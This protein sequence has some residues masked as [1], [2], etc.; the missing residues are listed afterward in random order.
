[1]L[2]HRDCSAHLGF[3]V[4]IEGL[5]DLDTFKEDIQKKNSK[6]V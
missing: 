6:V 3:Y 5:K 2:V 4:S 1:V